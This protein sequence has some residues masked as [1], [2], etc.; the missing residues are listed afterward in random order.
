MNKRA[1][2]FYAS[3]DDAITAAVVLAQFF[4]SAGEEVIV[5]SEQADGSWSVLRS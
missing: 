2:H 5:K 4:E 3:E 1:E